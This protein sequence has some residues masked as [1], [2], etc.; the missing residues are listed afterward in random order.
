MDFVLH[1]KQ[2]VQVGGNCSSTLTTHP[3]TPQGTLAGP[4]NFKLLIND[5]TIDQEYIKYVDDPT[6]SSVS[7]NPQDSSLQTAADHLVE[8]TQCNSMVVKEQK[9]KEMLIYFGTKVDPTTIQK[10]K[11]DDEDTER[12]KAFKL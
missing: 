1:C 10:I 3:G 11:I 4:N 12:I 6:V 7:T 8:W 5:L 2:Y 9:T